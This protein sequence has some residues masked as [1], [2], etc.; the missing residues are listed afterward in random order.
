[1]PNPPFVIV[2]M[3]QGKVKREQELLNGMDGIAPYIAN[4]PTGNPS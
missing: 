2:E 1:M 4:N 3:W